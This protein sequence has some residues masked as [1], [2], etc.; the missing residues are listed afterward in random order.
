MPVALQTRSFAA[1]VSGEM[2]AGGGR[3]TPLAYT[4][5]ICA[6]GETFSAV[7]MAGPR[8]LML[9]PAHWVSWHRHVR[10]TPEFIIRS[11]HNNIPQCN[12]V[13]KVCTFQTYVDTL[14]IHLNT[15]G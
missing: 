10:A 8:E 7:A 13:R 1:D 4:A 11:R 6:G 9:P 12:R 5:G 2:K 3:A 14:V 15:R